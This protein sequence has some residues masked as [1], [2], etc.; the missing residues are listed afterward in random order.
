M[1]VELYFRAPYEKLKIDTVERALMNAQGIIF[2]WDVYEDGIFAS[3]LPFP[4]VLR[5][6]IKMQ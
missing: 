3:E 4:N 5:I 6:H 1:Q 2:S